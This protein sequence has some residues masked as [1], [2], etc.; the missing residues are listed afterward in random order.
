MRVGTVTRVVPSE[1][2]AYYLPH[3]LAPGVSFDTLAELRGA[4][5][6]AA[7]IGPDSPCPLTEQ[8]LTDDGNIVLGQVNGAP[9]ELLREH[10]AR[11]QNVTAGATVFDGD[12]NWG[13]SIS[14]GGQINQ[15]GSSAGGSGVAILLVNGAASRVTRINKDDAAVS[16]GGVE[17]LRWRCDLPACSTDSAVQ[18]VF[19]GLGN[20]ALSR[21]A[22][23]LLDLSAGTGVPWSAHT[24]DGTSANSVQTTETTGTVYL[25]GLLVPGEF[26]AL[27]ANGDGPYWTTLGIPTTADSIQ[28]IVRISSDA[29]TPIAVYPDLFFLDAPVGVVD[30]ASIGIDTLPAP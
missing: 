24:F 11:V 18:F 16:L 26:F 30:P 10:F 28:P 27:W 21:R 9:E 20:N 23:A 1:R 5:V 4:E 6:P 2:L 17:A 15:A 19:V 14:T 12:T 25:E 29:S 7:W 22:M 8:Y 3:P 13:C